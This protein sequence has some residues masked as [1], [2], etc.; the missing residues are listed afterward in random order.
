MRNLDIYKEKQ[1]KPYS[2]FFMITNIDRKQKCIK[3][4][5]QGSK[6]IYTYSSQ[7]GDFL[8]YKIIMIILYKLLS[9]DK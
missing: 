2:E 8:V 9:K 1:E 5:L 7:F 4:S 6:L 3:E